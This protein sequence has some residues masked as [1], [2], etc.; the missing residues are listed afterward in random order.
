MR[1]LRTV[2]ATLALS[3]GVIGTVHGAD[4]T[5]IERGVKVDRNAAAEKGD[6]AP[7]LQYALAATVTL[8]VLVVVCMPSRKA[9]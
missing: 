8:A 6:R 9:H 7:V 2:L 5:G 4:D 1:T 3:I